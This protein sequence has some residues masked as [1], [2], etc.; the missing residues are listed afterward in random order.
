[1][2]RVNIMRVPAFMGAVYKRSKPPNLRHGESVS[3]HFASGALSLRL[4]AEGRLSYPLANIQSDTPAHPDYWCPI[5]ARFP[6]HPPPPLP[7]T[8]RYRCPIPCPA[9]ACPFSLRFLPCLGGVR[10]AR[11]SRSSP[12]GPANAHSRSATRHG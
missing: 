6:W 7:D 11:L 4:E 12:Y 1:M 8:R 9:F 10:D 3:S 2:D 5:V